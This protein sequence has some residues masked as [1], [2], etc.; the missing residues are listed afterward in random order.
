MRKRAI[1]ALLL[2]LSLLL[3]GCGSAQGEEETEAR[4]TILAATYPV[5]L[6]VQAVTEGVDGVAVERLNTG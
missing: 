2:V 3:S 1:L 4:L 6:A 5:Y